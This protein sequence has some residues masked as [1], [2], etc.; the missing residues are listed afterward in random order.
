MLDGSL[1]APSLVVTTIAILLGPGVRDSAP[2]YWV[3]LGWTE[4]DIGANWVWGFP[5]TRTDTIA[6]SCA[7]GPATWNTSWNWLG[8][9]VELGAGSTKTTRGFGS[10]AGI[11][12]GRTNMNSP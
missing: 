2:W 3:T 11:V 10:G 4:V 12:A 9:S 6:M 5:S 7:S 1:L 8:V